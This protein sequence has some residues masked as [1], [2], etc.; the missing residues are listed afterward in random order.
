MDTIKGNRAIRVFMGLPVNSDISQ[1]FLD[2]HSK[3]HKSWDELMLVVEKCYEY[4]EL[5]NEQ[6]EAIVETFSGI[7][8]INETYKA[9]LEFIKSYN[10]RKKQPVKTQNIDNNDDYIFVTCPNCEQCEQHQVDEQRHHLQSFDIVEWLEEEKGVEVS[11]MNCHVCKT[12]FKLTWK[13]NEK[14]KNP[15]L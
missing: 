1:A 2:K 9:V 13:Y 8:D 15:I 10:E 3:Y 7:I 5:H 4:G 11:L 14:F 6:R 12:D